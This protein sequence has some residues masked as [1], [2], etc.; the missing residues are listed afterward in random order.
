M[1]A[2]EEQDFSLILSDLIGLDEKT[3]ELLIESG[4]DN[5]ESLQLA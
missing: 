5:H 3:V 4:F 2:N 1:E